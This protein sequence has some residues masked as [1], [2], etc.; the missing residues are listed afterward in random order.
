MHKGHLDQERQGIRST[1]LQEPRPT[2]QQTKKNQEL[3]EL[4]KD[5]TDLLQSCNY[6]S[7][8]EQRTTN[9]DFACSEA[10]GKM[11]TEPTGR[12]LVQSTKGNEYILCGYYYNSNH[13][14][15]E[16]MKNRKKASQIKDVTTIIKKLKAAGLRPTFH[17]LEN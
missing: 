14:F 1:K 16:T 2:L 4:S 15:A 8:I 3:I 12:F 10:T 17:I 5:D 9:F 6:P 7:P 13:V 11:Y